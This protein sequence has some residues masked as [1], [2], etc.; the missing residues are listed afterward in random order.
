M[1]EHGRIIQKRKHSLL[2][3]CISTAIGFV[4]AYLFNY[5]CLPLFGF[6]PSHG[7]IF[8]YTVIFTVL[9]IIRGYFVRRLFNWLH[10]R[11]LL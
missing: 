5:I 11:E 8:W 7:Q 4:L 9:S 3:A 1:A 6:Y 2:E 10:A